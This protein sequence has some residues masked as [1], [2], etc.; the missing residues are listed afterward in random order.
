V[1]LDPCE[2]AVN[3]P[4]LY[5]GLGKNQR[6]IIAFH[7]PF[8]V[9]DWRGSG[10]AVAGLVDFDDESMST[11]GVSSTILAGATALQEMTRMRSTGRSQFSLVEDVTWQYTSDKTHV[12][13]ELRG[14][15]NAS[16]AEAINEVSNN[17]V[18]MLQRLVRGESRCAGP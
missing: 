13:E 5:E 2:A 8:Y 17:L 12:I 10:A 14:V 18:D 15:N 4:L 11:N 7:D 1:H 16:V 9:G 6:Y 3:N